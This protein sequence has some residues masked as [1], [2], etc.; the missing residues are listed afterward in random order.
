VKPILPFLL[1]VFVVISARGADTAAQVLAEINF[2]RTQPQCYAKILAA[3]QTQYRSGR[4]ALLEAVRQLEKMKPVQAL[5]AS[6]GLTAAAAV[7]VAD[8]GSNGRCGHRGKGF[9][10]P[11]SRIDRHG[12]RCGTAGENICYGR[13]DPR[14]IVVALL[15][16]AGVLSRGHRKNLLSPA[17]RT[18][19]IACGPHARY[20][21]MCVMDFAAFFIEKPGLLSKSPG[22]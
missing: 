17:F 19:G 9:S 15:V 5:A 7:H 22:K 2:A 21:T 3:Q 8:A 14:D 11:W 12:R 20:G 18:A 1:L 16:D 10:S 6:P 4:G 13:R